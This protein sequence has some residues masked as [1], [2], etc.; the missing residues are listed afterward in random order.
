M[1]KTTITPEEIDKLVENIDHVQLE[2]I[3]KAIG[4]R[5]VRKL[6]NFIKEKE[7]TDLTEDYIRQCLVLNSPNRRNR[8]IY[9][10]L[11]L[12]GEKSQGNTADFATAASFLENHT[13]KY[14][15]R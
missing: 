5:F 13:A 7:N 15:K 8:I 9:Y 3:K 1:E 10:A 6:K 12:A 2:A 11:L 14:D 4:Y